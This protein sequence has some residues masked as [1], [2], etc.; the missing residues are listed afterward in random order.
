MDEYALYKVKK[1]RVVQQMQRNIREIK[2][3]RNQREHAQVALEKT[4]TNLFR[5][6]EDAPMLHISLSDFNHICSVDTINNIVEGEAR[7]TYDALSRF[8]LPLGYMPAVVPQLKTI[9]LGGAVA[10]GGI[11]SSSFKE[12]FVHETIQELE[13]LTGTGE[14]LTCNR[15]NEHKDLF[16]GFANSYATLGYALKIKAKITP[17]KP[18]VKLKHLRYA[19][20][21]EYFSDLEKI[22]VGKKV[23]FVDGTVFGFDQMYITTA[24]FVN[25]APQTSDYTFENIYYK[26]IQE[27]END[28]LSTYDYLWRWDTDW[29][30]CSKHLGMQNKLVRMLVGKNRL[31]SQTYMKIKNWNNAHNFFSRFFSSSQK[32]EVIIQDVEIPIKNAEE[33]LSFFIGEIGIMPIWICPV[34]NKTDVFPLYETKLDTLYVNFG[35]WD[36]IPTTQEKGFFNRRV[37]Q[38]V[39]ELQGKKSLY[40]DSFYRQEEFWQLYGGSAYWQLKEKYDPNHVFP[41]LYEKCV[42]KK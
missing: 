18:F 13:I 23:D 5:Y 30:W 7:T 8:L 31:N 33:F 42:L 34:Q 38:K 21:K 9:T 2:C 26:S 22:C 28:F 6:K 37:E 1:E 24:Q 10:G 39:E 41:D 4:T 17:T 36:M 27:K 19:N 11:E 14:V 35:F 3:A 40:S 32:K 20:K 15:T 16:F 12:G 25:D 29:F